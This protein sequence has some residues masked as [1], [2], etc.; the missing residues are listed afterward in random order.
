MQRPVVYSKAPK[1][2]LSRSELSFY[3]GLCLDL[4]IE[5]ERRYQEISKRVPAY[6]KAKGRLLNIH[7][8]PGNYDKEDMVEAYGDLI[9]SLQEVDENYR[10]NPFSADKSRIVGVT[11]PEGFEGFVR[12]YH[13]AFEESQI[14]TA[15]KAAA[16]ALAL[17][18]INAGIEAVRPDVRARVI[19]ELMDIFFLPHPD[20]DEYNPEGAEALLAT[21]DHD[22]ETLDSM[23]DFGLGEV[24]DIII[25]ARLRLR[26]TGEY[27]EEDVR[28]RFELAKPALLVHDRGDNELYLSQV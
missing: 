21:L 11:F 13:Q 2:G 25:D 14:D 27:D 9:T 26:G 20:E 6:T 7:N 22:D 8:C 28:E 19:N 5:V 12:R 3:S 23:A 16:E 4:L 24:V 10:I 18:E 15:I 17:G 1:E